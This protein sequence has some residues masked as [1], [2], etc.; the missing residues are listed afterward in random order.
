MPKDTRKQTVQA[1]LLSLTA[2][3]T[4][5]MKQVDPYSWK[6]FKILWKPDFDTKDSWL[7]EGCQAE[8]FLCLPQ[9]EAHTGIFSLWPQGLKTK[10]PNLTF[11]LTCTFSKAFFFF[12]NKWTWHNDLILIGCIIF[13]AEL[14]G[15]YNNTMLYFNELHTIK[16]KKLNFKSTKIRSTDYLV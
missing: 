9:S 14:S 8:I 6:F 7:Q 4:K 13:L 10:R 5:K 16:V 3:K 1:L 2:L 15:L 12:L 11:I